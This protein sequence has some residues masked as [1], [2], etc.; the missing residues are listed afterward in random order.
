MHQPDSRVARFTL[1]ELLVVIAIISILA[2]MLLPAL[3]QAKDTARAI[4]CTGNLKQLG[5]T[6]LMYADD[7]ND[8]LPP[9]TSR[10]YTAAGPSRTLYAWYD[11]Y[12]LSV[13]L[14]PTLPWSA[15][16]SKYTGAKS[17]LNCP[18]A[19]AANLAY[20]GGTLQSLAALGTWEVAPQFAMRYMANSNILPRDDQWSWGILR[21]VA[22]F[23]SP[24]KYILLED[25]DGAAF[26]GG[27]SR[28]GV[29]MR[30]SNNQVMNT[31]MLDGHAD[32]FNISNYS[33]WAQAA[34]VW[35]SNGAGPFN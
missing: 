31:C 33:T 16:P 19:S 32:H 24:Y 22:D 17:V 3:G 9:A 2:S 20:S 5:M 34:A 21:R 27:D 10:T 26:S 30:H 13:G 29:R 35:A 18:A 28:T 23:R 12:E 15:D 4:K 6:T 14:P 8:F 25:G 1:I 7:Y 11:Y